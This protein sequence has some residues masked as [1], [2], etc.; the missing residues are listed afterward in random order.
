VLVV[1]A[2]LIVVMDRALLQGDRVKNIK[3]SS[4]TE[5][6]LIR[7]RRE[8]DIKYIPLFLKILNDLY[9]KFLQNYLS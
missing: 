2:H 9:A 4:T 8:N 3:M 6:N 5:D 7:T 1:E